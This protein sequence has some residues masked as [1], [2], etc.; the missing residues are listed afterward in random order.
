MPL[1]QF[2]TCIKIKGPSTTLLNL[3][4]LQTNMSLLEIMAK[5]Y[6]F[7]SMLYENEDIMY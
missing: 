5:V 4:C 7:D 6:T 3:P 1:E 2:I